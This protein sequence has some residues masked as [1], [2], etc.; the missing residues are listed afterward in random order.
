MKQQTFFQCS[1]YLIVTHCS[2]F[3]WCSNKCKSITK[4]HIN[5]PIKAY[6]LVFGKNTNAFLRLWGISNYF[7]AIANNEVWTSEFRFVMFLHSVSVG[8]VGH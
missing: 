1:I 7:H 6:I 2:E 4:T 5:Y 3:W 8:Q